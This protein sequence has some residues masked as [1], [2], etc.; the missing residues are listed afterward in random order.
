M[1]SHYVANAHFCA[2]LPL[3]YEPL[4]AAS[5]S[6]A[7]VRGREQRQER[8]CFLNETYNHALSMISID[9]KSQLGH[10][11]YLPQQKIPLIRSGCA[12]LAQFTFRHHFGYRLASD[13]DVSM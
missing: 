4:G 11:P 7:P 12:M 9:L 10:Q 1:Q 3:C 2:I 13:H 5:S 6:Q 8:I